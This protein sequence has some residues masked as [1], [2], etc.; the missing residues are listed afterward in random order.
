MRARRRIPDF[1]RKCQ[2]KNCPEI[3]TP[4][5]S[6]RKVRK[7]RAS[8]LVTG[9]LKGILFTGII[10][11]LEIFLTNFSPFSAEIRWQY[12]GR[13]H[14]ELPRRLPLCVSLVEAAPVW[15]R[16]NV[17]SPNKNASWDTSE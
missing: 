14:D 11:N 7:T 10:D 5:N 2:G 12:C 16:S 8:T 6:D 1:A 9:S 4:M 15:H 13:L 3:A 17:H